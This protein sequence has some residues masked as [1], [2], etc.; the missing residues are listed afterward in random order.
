MGMTATHCIMHEA[1]GGSPSVAHSFSMS[2]RF[3]ETCNG[4]RGGVLHGD[5]FEVKVTLTHPPVLGVVYHGHLLNREL[6]F[7]CL[8]GQLIDR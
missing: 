7:S 2:T 4:W 1:G 8:I 6:T 3:E 5:D